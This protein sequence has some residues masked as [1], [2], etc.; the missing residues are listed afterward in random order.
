MDSRKKIKSVF[1]LCVFIASLHQC[2][3]QIAEANGS[4]GV[5]QVGVVLAMDSLVGRVSNMCISM[6]IEDFY[7]EHHNFNTRLHLSRRD[8]GRD[9]VQAA[10]AALDLINNVEVQAI[11]GPQT[12]TEAQ[13]LSNVA[14]KSQIPIMSFSATSPSLSTTH[15][16]YFIRATLS[17]S[18]QAKPIASLIKFFKWR[19]AIAICEDTD[20]GAGFVPY[21]NDALIDIGSHL[22]LGG[23]IPSYASDELI[24]KELHKVM[25]MQTRV[26]I[27]HMSSPL[28]SR[29]FRHAKQLGMMSRDYAWIITDGL[30]SLLNSMDPWIIDSM[31]GVLGVRA[32]I[33]ETKR[34]DNFSYRYK[35]YYRKEYP[36]EIE[37]PHVNAFCLRAYDATRVLAL[38]MEKSGVENVGSRQPITG[39][40]AGN[41]T[42][43]SST[44]PRLLS[45]LLDIKLKGLNGNL[46]FVNGEIQ[47]SSFEI[48]NVVGKSVREIGFWSLET[49]ISREINR[50]K[51]DKMVDDV[52]NLGLV[53]WPGESTVI[54]SGWVVTTNGSKMKIGVPVTE[55]FREFLK[56]EWGPLDGRSRA[57]GFSVDVFDAVVRA[58]PYRLEYEYVPFADNQR[59][60]A[61][62]YNDLVYQV[63]LGKYDA[64]VGDVAIIANRSNYVDFTPP[65]TEPGV[66]MIVPMRKKRG[67]NALAFLKP[68]T[69]ELWV[70]ASCFLFFM[71]FVVWFLEHRMNEDF[72]GPLSEQV[73]RALYFS[74]STLIFSQRDKITSNLTRFVVILWLFMVLILT[75]SYTANLASIL[76][77]EQLQPTVT[78]IQT[79]IKNEDNVGYQG[80]S[81]VEDLLKEMGIARSKLQALH[82]VDEYAKALL[83]GSSHGGVAAIF[84]EIPYIKCF[85][86]NHPNNFMMAGLTYKTGG[87]GFVFPKNSPL[88][89]DISSAVLKVT[90]GDTMASLESKWFRKQNTSSSW[91]SSDSSKGL[92]LDSFWG[93]FLI[94]GTASVGALIVFFVGLCNEHWN[95]IVSETTP[96]NRGFW[97][98]II[99][100]AKHYD[101]M[102]L[103]SHTFKRKQ[104]KEG[105][106]ENN[107]KV[108]RAPNSFRVPVE[109]PC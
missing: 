95:R 39:Q 91:S 40:T 7:R 75:S 28:A 19:Q 67:S 90:E 21:L 77:V 38:A 72:R 87:F 51:I 1:F 14:N 76:T 109:L 61:G 49:G 2:F 98:R 105:R 36:N 18:I 24:K 107:K 58:L 47:G 8:S 23:L 103:S 15:T 54:P 5:V 52:A 17:D 69:W 10:S 29:F 64:V 106:I 96:V 84:D 27:V 74:F 26:F 25:T 44:G 53:I 86:S 4:R 43:I 31:Q 57:M 73:G 59:K 80:N 50:K 63:F 45:A 89:S 42:G 78:D 68:L 37:I 30:A 65:Y 33:E 11:I 97:Q 16:P 71:A 32:Y 9:V 88:L 101:E 66:S 46:L 6:A 93:L 108:N 35:R 102:D 83:K 82:T 20:Y 55:G 3:A 81:F 79:L 34:L 100:M 70:T 104:W 22:H 13:F 62:T 41:L 48:V 56:V 94:V 99:H 12:S 85:L 92:S 60:T